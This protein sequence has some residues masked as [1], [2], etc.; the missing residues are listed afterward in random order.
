MRWLNTVFALFLGGITAG[1]LALRY[2]WSV[3]IAVPIGMLAGGLLYKPREVLTL[4]HQATREVL[5]YN[6]LWALRETARTLINLLGVGLGGVIGSNILVGYGLAVPSLLDPG[7]AFFAG[8][9]ITCAV[10]AALLLYLG[11]HRELDA[12]AVGVERRIKGL[13]S[14]GGV[15]FGLFLVC[16][17][18]IAIPLGLTM[19]I[20]RFLPSMMRPI[21]HGLARTPSLIRMVIT[22]TPTIFFR[23]VAL[24]ATH[25]RLVIMASIATGSLIG[26]TVGTMMLCG[27]ASVVI[28]VTTTLAAKAVVRRRSATAT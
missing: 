12:K 19:A 1:A 25:D 17:V 21:G 13:T 10:S 8:A 5:G 14:F 23:F 6:Y 15:N 27:L 7:R 28:G 11:R 16:W 22:I 26:I 4:L 20:T 18:L 3:L 9:L 2:H 24:V